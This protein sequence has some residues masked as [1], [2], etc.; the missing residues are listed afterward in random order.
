MNILALETATDRCS[1]ALEISGDLIVRAT[2]EPRVH[3][4]RLLGMTEECLR[5]GGLKPADVD[6]LT[7]GRGPGSFTGVRIA[8][9][10]VQGLAFGLERLVVPVSTLACMAVGAW[11]N[12]ACQKVAVCVD[13]RMGECYWGTFTVDA[14]GVATLQGAELIAEPDSLPLPGEPGWVG[15]GTGWDVFPQLAAAAKGCVDRVFPALLPEARD[16]IATASAAN[17][18]GESIPAEQALPMYL[19]DRVAWRS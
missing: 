17:R 6:L 4:G 3:A 13:A 5:E 8:T 12:H 14:A 9:G 10:V 16:L 11:R 2:D 7:F 19:R 15:V 1:V 18:R